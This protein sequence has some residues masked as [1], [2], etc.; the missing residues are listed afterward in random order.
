MDTND[1]LRKIMEGARKTGIP[2]EILP[3]I[4]QSSDPSE[5][6]NFKKVSMRK[7]YAFIDNYDGVLE[8]NV[9]GICEPPMVSYNDFKLGKNALAML[10]RSWPENDVYELKI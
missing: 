7:F 2:V 1:V 9:H 10:A 8:R 4:P 6:Y 5:Q 3:I